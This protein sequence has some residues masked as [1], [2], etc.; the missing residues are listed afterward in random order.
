MYKIYNINNNKIADI[1][2]YHYIDDKKKLC[3]GPSPFRN[4]FNI[5]Q[6]KKKLKE[7][8]VELDFRMGTVVVIFSFF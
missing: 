5:H 8:Y 1:C 3:F 6:G 2:F 7:N 4:I